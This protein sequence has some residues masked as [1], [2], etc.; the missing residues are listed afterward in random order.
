M[1]P[2]RGMFLGFVT[3]RSWCAKS[4]TS[5]TNSPRTLALETTPVLLRLPHST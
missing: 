4:C 1:D 2:T 3:A 5:T